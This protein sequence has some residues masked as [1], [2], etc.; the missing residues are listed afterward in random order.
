M[1]R[2]LL[3]SVCLSIP[4]TNKDQGV[5]AGTSCPF[6]DGRFWGL[7]SSESNHTSAIPEL[8]HYVSEWGRDS[9]FLLLHIEY[10][11][12]ILLAQ[13]ANWEHFSWSPHL[14]RTP[15]VK[16]WVQGGG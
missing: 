6:L 1:T 12:L 15:R 8:Y 9:T 5:S 7:R 16:T 3:L 13:F 4:C 10:K 14:Q 2:F 11:T